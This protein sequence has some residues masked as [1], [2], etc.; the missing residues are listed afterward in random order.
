MKETPNA[1]KHKTRLDGAAMEREG[2]P[3]LDHHNT[4]LDGAV[5]T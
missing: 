1:G 4:R 3:M 5:M 2:R